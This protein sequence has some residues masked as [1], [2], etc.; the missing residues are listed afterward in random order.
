RPV[1]GKTGTSNQAKDT[2]FI[3]YST[4]IV[5][6]TWTGYDDARPLGGREQG[7]ITALPAWISFMRAAHEKR[8]AT[9]F[10]RPAGIVTVKIDPK[11]GLLAYHGE[12]EALD[13]VLLRGTRPDAHPSP[14]SGLPPEGRPAATPPPA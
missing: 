2:W 4:E 9:E 5:C 7:A 1:A 10:P 12:E 6:A 13:E 8:P 14:D 3:G 11:T